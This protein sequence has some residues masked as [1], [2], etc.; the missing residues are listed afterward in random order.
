MIHPPGNN[1]DITSLLDEHKRDLIIL[2]QDKLVETIISRTGELLKKEI[3]Q[4]DWERY[5][6]FTFY[7]MMNTVN[8]SDAFLNVESRMQELLTNI[9]DPEEMLQGIRD[10]LNEILTQKG[11]RKEKN[12][13]LVSEIADFLTL[14]YNKPLS[15]QTLSQKFGLVPSYISTLFKNEMG[16]SPGEYILTIRMNHAKDHLINNKNL[17]TREVAQMVGYSDPLYFSRVFKKYFGKTPS[18]VRKE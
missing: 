7:T 12:E 5:L 9:F 4:K 15:N 8:K 18:Q 13:D 17:M 6:K 16:I 10:I 11:I 3:T 1:N 2:T 14:N